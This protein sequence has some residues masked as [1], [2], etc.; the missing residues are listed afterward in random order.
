MKT[1]LLLFIGSILLHLTGFAQSVDS[2]FIDGVVYVKVKDTSSMDLAPYQFNDPVLNNI[3]T[4]Y[5]IDTIVNPFPGLNTTLDKTYRVLFQSIGQI[6]LLIAAFVALPYIEYAE[7]APLYRTTHVPNDIQPGQ[8][9]LTKINAELAWDIDKGSTSITIAIVDNAVSTTHEDLQANIWINPGEIP[10][11]LLDDDLNGFTDDVNGYDVA[12][13]DNNPNPPAMSTSASPFVHGTHCAGIASAATNNSKGIASIGYK[14]KII[15]VKCSKNAAT[16]EGNSLPNAYDG[17][18]YAIQAGADIIS[19]SWGGSSG[20]FLTG[21][22]LMDAANALDIILVAAAG[23]DNSNAAF[24]PASYDHVISV[25][26]TNQVDQKSSFSNYGSNIDVMAPGTGIYSTLS[27]PTNDEYG[28]LNGTSM[29]CPLVAG[30][31]ALIKS[32]VPSLN[33]SQV[34]TKLKNGC[35]NIDSFNPAYIGELGAGRIDAFQTLGGIS[36]IEEESVSTL[37]VF[38]NPSKGT[39][40]VRSEILDGILQIFDLSGK[41]VMSYEVLKPDN[42]IELNLEAGTYIIKIQ[43]RGKKVIVY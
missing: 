11:N 17:V 21:E 12:D 30:L 35:S 4:T 39:V 42:F 9:A 13:D 14:T 43:N 20:N 26:S 19:M 10:G 24:Y 33:S 36:G 7:K 8:W 28:S 15:A 6:D 38:P 40:Y 18:Y 37:E 25:G 31:C 34:Q 29:A 23:N 22:N 41:E 27:S 16:D 32:N 2:N 5:G 1:C 3:Y